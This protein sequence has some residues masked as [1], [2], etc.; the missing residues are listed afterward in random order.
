MKLFSLL[1][2]F[3]L[4]SSASANIFECKQNEAQFI[5]QV[6]EATIIR[7]DQGVRDCAYTM[8]FQVFNPS[9]ICP[10]DWTSAEE[11]EII[12]YN[13]RLDARDGDVISGVLIEGKDGTLVIE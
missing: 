3:V 8:R 12:D 6:R 4:A 1:T 11:R 2:V 10:I 7:I 13:C 5:G 9:R